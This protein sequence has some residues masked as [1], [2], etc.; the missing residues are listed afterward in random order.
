M[1]TGPQTEKEEPLTSALEDKFKVLLAQ[2]LVQAKPLRVPGDKIPDQEV[3]LLGMHGS[4]L[5][6]MRAFIP[7]K[8]SSSLWCRRDVPG[9]NPILGDG[10][11]GLFDSEES[12][13]SS[14]S[15]SSP[16][17]AHAMHVEDS[18][19]SSRSPDGTSAAGN[20]TPLPSR[21]E[22]LNRMLA[23]ARL[24]ALDNEPEARTFRIL[25]GQEFD[26]WKREDFQA[27]VTMLVGLQMY[28]HSGTSQCGVMQEAFRRH[29]IIRVPPRFVPRPPPVQFARHPLSDIADSLVPRSQRQ[30]PSG[31]DGGSLANH[32]YLHLDAPRAEGGGAAGEVDIGALDDED[33]FRA[34]SEERERD[35]AASL[36]AEIAREEHRRAELTR[37]IEQIIRGRT[38]EEEGRL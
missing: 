26:L 3:F 17:T 38:E 23:S 5:H 12:S 22:R 27:A 34:M 16:N 24:A 25:A 32:P 19:L 37:M 9:P 6:L 2:F 15:S 20:P 29:P 30:H 10:D 21:R 18:D 14:S 8:K 31:R 33:L 13:S 28:L 1:L 4:K 7:G 35:W 11:I 36:Q